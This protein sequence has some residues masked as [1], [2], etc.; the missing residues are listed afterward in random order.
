MR[1][2]PNCRQSHTGGC[3]MPCLHLCKKCFDRIVYTHGDLNQNAVNA[4]SE[5]Y[6]DVGM[7]HAGPL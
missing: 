1:T 6:A 5:A 4:I 3:K 7:V 2:C